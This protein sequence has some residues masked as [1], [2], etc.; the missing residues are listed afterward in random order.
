MKKNILLISVESPEISIAEI[1]DGRLFDLHIER[2][3]RVLNDIFKG[4]VENVVPGM[5][6][7]FVNIGLTRNALIYAGDID[8]S[9][10]KAVSSKSQT[11]TISQLI[12]SGEEVLV[13]IARPPVGV[14]GARVTKSLSLA[15]RYVVLSSGAEGVGVSR[16]IESEDE[17]ARLR[18]IGDKLRPL[19]HGLVIRTEAEGISENHLH[20]DVQSLL[21]LLQS[22]RERAQKAVSPALIHREAGILG[23]IVRDR[24]NIDVE[25]VWIDSQ[26]EFDSFV[27]LTKVSAPPLADRIILYNEAAPLFRKFG[28]MEEIVRA[29]QRTISLAHGGSLVID[30][31]EALSAI[32]VNTGKFTGKTHLAD[33]VLQTNLEAV[34]YNHSA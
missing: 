5:D 30:E 15:G 31:T 9:I 12:K 11:S 3:G 23:R 6:A 22:I 25:E 29:Q 16:R 4:R 17:R 13:Q 2:G 34:D 21:L 7:A 14:K 20:Q 8:V 19:D 1:R 32:D 24:L 27:E 10:T 18:R 33:T 26:E 28:V